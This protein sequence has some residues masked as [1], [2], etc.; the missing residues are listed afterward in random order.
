MMRGLFSIFLHAASSLKQCGLPLVKIASRRQEP[1]ELFT[2]SNHI[3]TILRLLQS[4]LNV[5]L[6]LAPR[7]K[8]LTALELCH[9][10]T[11]PQHHNYT[12][13][14]VKTVGAQ[15][16]GRNCIISP[17][18]IEAKCIENLLLLGLED[19]ELPTNFTSINDLN[20][21]NY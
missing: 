16:A 7:A 3:Q 14:C 18:G 12:L 8:Q 6:S 11:R 9:K 4:T 19:D 2:C 10:P 13:C 1:R 17:L 21:Q 20:M 15:I 5:E